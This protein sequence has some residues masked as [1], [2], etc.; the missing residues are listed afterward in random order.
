MAASREHL[1]SFNAILTKLARDHRDPSH[2]DY[3][4][5]FE[6]PIAPPAE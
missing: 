4:N 3:H 6:R 2:G 5:A 1:H